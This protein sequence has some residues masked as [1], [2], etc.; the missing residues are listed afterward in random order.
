MRSAGESWSLQAAVVALS[1][2]AGLHRINSEQI[3]LREEILRKAA[4]SHSY[5]VLTVLLA[6]CSLMQS[7]RPGSARPAF[8]PFE[9]LLTDRDRIC[10][11]D[12]LRVVAANESRRLFTVFVGHYGVHSLEHYYNIAIS[13]SITAS[14]SY[15]NLIGLSIRNFI[16]GG[17]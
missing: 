12:G 2:E 8:V 14:G 1:L 10:F 16:S 13:I 17:L 6:T 5:L 9:H 11:V 3:Y 15:Y 4:P 7:I